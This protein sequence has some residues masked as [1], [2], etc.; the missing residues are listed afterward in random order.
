MT[1]DL[2][3]EK[4]LIFWVCAVFLVGRGLISGFGSFGN[5]GF[6]SWRLDLE[7]KLIVSML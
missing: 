1:S 3:V 2:L 7:V 4:D 5:F 6:E